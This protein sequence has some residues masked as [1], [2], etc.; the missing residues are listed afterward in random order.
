MN[1][2]T[3]DALLVM[4]ALSFVAGALTLMAEWA[5]QER[6]RMRG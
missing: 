2:K 3:V 6:R 4:G 1:P 5:V